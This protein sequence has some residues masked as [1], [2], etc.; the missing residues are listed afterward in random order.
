MSSARI[1]SPRSGE[2]CAAAPVA[3]TPGCDS[4]SGKKVMFGSTPAIIST[5]ERAA[6]TVTT[7]APQ[8]ADA[9]DAIS[10]APG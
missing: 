7:P 3:T 6:A 9:R 4:A 1:F 10:I 8:R 5:T 2:S